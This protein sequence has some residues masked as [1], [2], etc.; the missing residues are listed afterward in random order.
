MQLRF[1]D[2]HSTAVCSTLLDYL[3]E[4]T[5]DGEQIIRGTH[6]YGSHMTDPTSEHYL[7]QA[8]AYAEETL[9]APGFRTA[10][11]ASPTRSYTVSSPVP[12]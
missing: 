9:R 3:L 8:E 12:D 1:D 11:R 10:N 6:Q 7:D 4:W 2:D 5:A